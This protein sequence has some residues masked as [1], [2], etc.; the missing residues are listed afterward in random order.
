MAL[1]ATENFNAARGFDD[2]EHLDTDPPGSWTQVV[3]TIDLQNTGTDGGFCPDQGG[4]I[5]HLYFWNE[6]VFDADQYAECIIDSVN[7]GD[8]TGV[9]LRVQETD[10]G[11]GVYTDNDSYYLFAIEAGGETVLSNAGLGVDAG[12]KLRL[13]VTGTD[14]GNDISIVF[15]HDPDGGGYDT[16]VT[17]D[18]SSDT[19]SNHEIDGGSAGVTGYDDH[20]NARADNWEGGN[21]GAPGGRFRASPL[22]RPLASPLGGPL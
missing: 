15:K 12:D 6:D 4:G 22:N 20:N 8:F 3:G 14:A 19:G 13:E 11:Y 10:I 17:H 2:N 1:P 5:S 16:I 9:A 21:L 18:A 7:G